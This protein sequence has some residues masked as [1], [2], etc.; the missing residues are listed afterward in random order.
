MRR[1]N[2]INKY[3]NKYDYKSYLEIGVHRGKCFD[4][5]NIENKTGVDPDEF[6]RAT[7]FM[8]SDDFFKQL[9]KE[10][11]YDI[12]FL[13]GM[14]KSPQL[15]IDIFNSLKHLEEGGTIICHD[16]SPRSEKYQEVPRTQRGWNG[17]IWRDFVML[18]ILREDLEAFTIDCDEGIGIIRKGE[19]ENFDIECPL[20]YKNLEEN[21]K[22]W[23]NLI[24]PEY[25]LKTM[26]D[27]I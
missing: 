16:I 27:E 1:Y 12:I 8:T 15:L 23:L 6:S 26:E 24:S 9:D 14:H 20:I 22:E 18:R 4:R 13:D 7:V 21:R 3:I 10:E 5:I 2:I 11:R 25:W 17:N 19:S